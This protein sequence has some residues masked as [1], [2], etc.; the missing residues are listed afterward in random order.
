MALAAVMTVP[1]TKD[2]FSRIP[3]KVARDCPAVSSREESDLDRRPPV[4][5]TIEALLTEIRAEQ[6]QQRDMLA[7]ILRLLERGRGARDAAD[8]ALLVAIAE[9]IGD[10]PFTS[11]Q[12][13]AHAEADPALREALLAADITTPRELG[14]LCRRLEG[15]PLAGWCL[16]RVA[17]HREGVVWCVRVFDPHTRTA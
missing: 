13:M 6:A 8:V 17:A 2:H 16:E 10:R 15:A 3:R 4:G 14:T 9:A 5:V 7:A 11:A 1:E 12:L